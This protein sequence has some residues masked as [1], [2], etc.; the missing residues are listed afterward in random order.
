MSYAI[1]GLA[2]LALLHFVYESILAPSFRMKLHFELQALRD[3][4]RRLQLTSGPSP[5]DENFRYLDESLDAL[6]LMLHRFD[7]G[8]LAA[9]GREMRRNPD[10]R[11][12][13]ER[14][15]RMLNECDVHEVVRARQQIVRIATRALLV[16]HGAWCIYIVPVAFGYFGLRNV[17]RLIVATISLPKPDLFRIAPN[18]AQRAVHAR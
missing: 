17:R 10:L 7:T 3:D 15:R 1:F 2:L 18:S 9:V 8:T 13:V 12:R 6:T 14:R 5:S 4:L 11:G 16:N